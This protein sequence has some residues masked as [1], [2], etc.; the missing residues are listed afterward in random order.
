MNINYSICIP[1]ERDVNFMSLCGMVLTTEGIVAFTDSKATKRHWMGHLVE[2]KDRNPKKLIYNDDIVIV[3]TGYNQYCKNGEY[4]LPLEELLE[5]VITYFSATVNP[6]HYTQ[7]QL[8][9]MI[10]QMLKSPLEESLSLLTEAHYL[11][12][13]GLKR[14]YYSVSAI[15]ISKDSQIVYQKKVKP[16]ENLY[17]YIGD[18]TYCKLMADLKIVKRYSI[19]EIPQFIKEVV[20]HMIAINDLSLDYNPVGGEI[21]TYT[22]K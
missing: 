14:V 17:F 16:G 19:E 1:K 12:L 2:D 8:I 4:H 21:L 13:V 11:F 7:E 18:D 6:E 9:K 5:K 20:S 3:T 22:F 10:Y 15:E